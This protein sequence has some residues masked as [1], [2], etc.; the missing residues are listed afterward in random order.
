VGQAVAK[1]NDAVQL[2]SGR[3]PPKEQGRLAAGVLE[4]VD[5]LAD[6]KSKTA[7]WN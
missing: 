7:S 5:D 2:V 4:A 3:V 1:I 6:V